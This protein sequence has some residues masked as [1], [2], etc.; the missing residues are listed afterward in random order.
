MA[1]AGSG[2]THKRASVPVKSNPAA[3]LAATKWASMVSVVFCANAGGGPHKLHKEVQ[4]M[5]LK[6]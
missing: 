1:D 4:A 5:I 2:A 3:V 6:A